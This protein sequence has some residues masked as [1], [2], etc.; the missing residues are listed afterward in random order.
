LSFLQAFGVA[1]SGVFGLFV[2]WAFFFVPPCLHRGG[3]MAYNR[4]YVAERMA[5]VVIDADQIV[6]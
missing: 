3:F 1:I 5:A 2:F 4:Q 6:P